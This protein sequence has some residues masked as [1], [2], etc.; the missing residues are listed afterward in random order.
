MNRNEGKNRKYFLFHQ[1]KIYFISLQRKI[2]IRPE[3]NSHKKKKRKK[4][5]EEKIR[6]KGK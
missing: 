5:R 6:E 1:K 2:T 3:I 4:K